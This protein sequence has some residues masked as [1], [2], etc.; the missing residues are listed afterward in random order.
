M[1]HK[2]EVSAGGIVYKKID[3]KILWLITQHSQHKGWSFPK[4]L[5]GDENKGEPMEEA[6]LREVQEEG[7][8]K[9]KIVNKEP[10]KISY[11]YR[12]EDYLIDKNV[13]Y[14]LMEYI[15]GDPKDHDWEV[16]EARFLPQ[17]EL[18]QTLSFKTDKEAFQTILD[19]FEK[20]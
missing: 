11:K 17:D 13:Y 14:F 18:L 5:I 10:V 9:A 16:A 20:G 6:A 12:F 15:S 2:E 19:K 4:G 8:V 7:G 3:S 1:K